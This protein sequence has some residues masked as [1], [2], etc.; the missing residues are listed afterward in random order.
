M[1]TIPQIRLELLD[2]AKSLQNNEH[3]PEHVS[4]RI[5]YLVRNMYRRK[6]VRRAKVEHAHTTKELQLKIR[7]YAKANPKKSYAAIGNKFNVAIGRVSEALV[8]RRNVA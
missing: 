2:I 7:K 1:K 4:R 8:G 5:R 3:S 6:T